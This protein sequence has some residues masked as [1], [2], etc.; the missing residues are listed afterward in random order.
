MNL[1]G[2][3][4]SLVVVNISTIREANKK[5]IERKALKEI[6][7]NQDNIIA[8]LYSINNLKDNKI[9]DLSN[10]IEKLNAD[11]TK[12]IELNNKLSKSL[13]TQKFYKTIGLTLAGCSITTLALILIFQ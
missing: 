8:D 13:E 9:I 3:T 12:Y 4:D 11:N 7:A 10:E 6:V 1:F 5:L 2:Q